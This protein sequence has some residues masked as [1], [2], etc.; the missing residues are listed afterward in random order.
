MYLFKNQNHPKI[1]HPWEFR[2][3]SMGRGHGPWAEIGAR[4]GDTIIIQSRMNPMPG[5]GVKN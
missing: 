4:G 3:R 2:K 5:N 1:G